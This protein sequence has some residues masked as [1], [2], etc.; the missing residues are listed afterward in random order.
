MKKFCV[1]TAIPYAS[2]KSHIGNVYED[3]L[4]DSIARYK[5]LKGYDVYFQV[6]LDEHGQKID[7]KAKELGVDP[8]KYV[9]DI[10]AVFKDMLDLL[11]ISYD[12]LIRTTDEDH[13]K[14]VEKIFTKLYEQGDIYKGKYEGL[15]CTPCE[16]FFLEKD[17]VDGKCPDCGREVSKSS[18]EAYFLKLSKYE[19]RDKI[20]EIAKRIVNEGLSVREVETLSKEQDEKK[21][22][23]IN[24]NVKTS[25]YS[26]VERELREVFDSKVKVS[27]N[28]I[29]ISF[30][31]ANDLDRI[32]EIMNIKIN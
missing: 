15:Y 11:N 29:E 14:K 3:V 9:D 25:E 5:R 18:E 17:L 13:C 1:T 7:D 16:S 31:N 10:A 26:Y 21:R 28:K 27:K 4:A 24:R 19:D 23:P 32:L 6:G 12:R 8:Q 22:N 30:A 20:L 2:G